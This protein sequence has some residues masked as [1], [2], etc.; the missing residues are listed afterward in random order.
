RSLTGI[1]TGAPCSGKATLYTALAKQ[2]NLDH[3]SLGDELR[4]LVSDTPSGHAARIKPF[5]SDSEFETCRNNLCAGTL[6]P[7]HLTPKYVKERVFPTGSN[8]QCVRMLIDGFPQD[9][10]RWVPFK[11]PAE[12]FWAPNRKSVL[13]VL[14]V[15]K[16]VALERFTKR[17]RPGD[18][19][20]RRFDEHM[21][22]ISEI[23][24]AMKDDD[25]TIHS[26]G[27]NDGDLQAM[28]ESLAE[29][30]GQGDYEGEK[31]SQT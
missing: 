7:V 20:E 27:K 25:M 31:Q 1:E 15:E 19:F 26:M 13:I 10:E 3:F 2:Y 8:L 28:V 6:G 18:V 24:E 29:L 12:P 16:E 21:E 9:A 5:F 11:E 17:A 30:L 4:S 22:L 23:V 14:D